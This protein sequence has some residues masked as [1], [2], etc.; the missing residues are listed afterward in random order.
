MSENL[1]NQPYSFAS[2]G[3]FSW[4][5]ATLHTFWAPTHRVVHGVRREDVEES[6]LPAN[7][8]NR[9]DVT[10]TGP[11]LNSLD[12]LR[13]LQ[14]NLNASTHIQTV[15]LQRLHTLT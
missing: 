8:A 6:L 12:P 15:T 14:L 9:D 7:T 5:C 11:E 10:S 13:N 3:A 4:L 2:D 1:N